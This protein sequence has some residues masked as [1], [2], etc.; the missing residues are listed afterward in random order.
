MSPER[1]PTCGG[2]VAVREAFSAMGVSGGVPE[3]KRRT[4]EY[5][6]SATDVGYDDVCSDCESAL[7]GAVKPPSGEVSDKGVVA[8][9]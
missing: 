6:F 5:R 4:L 3:H 8:K 7:R 1:C 9:T 2:L